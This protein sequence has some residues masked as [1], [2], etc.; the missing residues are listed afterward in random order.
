MKTC[1]IGNTG[2]PLDSPQCFGAGSLRSSSEADDC[3]VSPS[4]NEDVGL[5]DLTA[6]DN[7]NTRGGVL[8]ALPGCNPIQAGPADAIQQSGCGAT[9]QLNGFP[10]PA[11]VVRAASTYPSSSSSITTKPSPTPSST[12]A[13]GAPKSLISDWT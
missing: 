5:R 8:A 2:D 13:S 9:T 6:T 1:N 4:V 3:R 10:P 11:A 7:S 12:P